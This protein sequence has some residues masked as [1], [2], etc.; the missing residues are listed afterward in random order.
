MHVEMRSIVPERP[1]TMASLMDG[2]HG[3]RG[4]K[5]KGP[6]LSWPSR[7]CGSR[8]SKNDRIEVSLVHTFARLELS[9]ITDRIK[10]L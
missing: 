9:L 7:T 4:G 3:P 6:R 8:S 10:R 5:R 1:R 2:G